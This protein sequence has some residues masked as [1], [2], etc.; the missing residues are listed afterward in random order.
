MGKSTGSWA[1]CTTSSDSNQSSVEDKTASQVLNPNEPPS[2]RPPQ[3][4][5]QP[6][7][8][9]QPTPGPRDYPPV[10]VQPHAPPDM[11]Q[12]DVV[13]SAPQPNERSL[14]PALL[15]L[16]EVHQRRRQLAPCVC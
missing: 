1:E 8:P 2:A 11:Q 13:E 5:A 3:A 9:P 12:P 15:R 7:P 10:Q 14:P 6:S 16:R 4:A